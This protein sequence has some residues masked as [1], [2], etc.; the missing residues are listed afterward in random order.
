M[1]APQAV[2]ILR[3][4]GYPSPFDMARL[5]MIK[6]ATYMPI[7]K[8]ACDYLINIQKGV[9]YANRLPSIKGLRRR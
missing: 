7:I 6:E 5:V 1:N 2:S 9:R 3:E 8:S 4:A